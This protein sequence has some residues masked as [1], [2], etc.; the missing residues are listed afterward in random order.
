[1]PSQTEWFTCASLAYYAESTEECIAV[2]TSSGSIYTVSVIEGALESVI[3]FQNKE[4]ENAII[5]MSSDPDSKT[6]CAVTGN[7]A[8]LMLKL[9]KRKEWECI[10]DLGIE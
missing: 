4:T 1:M 7:G 2:G 6:L 10:F 8:T 3:G 5:C 9:R